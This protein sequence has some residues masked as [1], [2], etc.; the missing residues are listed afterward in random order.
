MTV[1]RL[2]TVATFV[3]DK[4]AG[5]AGVVDDM[6]AGAEIRLPPLMMPSSVRSPPGEPPIVKT[7]GLVIE[8]VLRLAMSSRHADVC[9]SDRRL[10]ADVGNHHIVDCRIGNARCVLRS[11][12]WL[13]P[14]GG[15]VPVSAAGTIP[16]HQR[17]DVR[18]RWDRRTR[19]RI[20]SQDVGE[21]A[22]RDSALGLH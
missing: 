3:D 11:A 9:R 8:S 7:R 14:V 6:C 17:V 20:G 13:R 19:L 4:T 1:D 21:I 5:A 18:L 12:G 2:I 10:R 22:A 15:R 16:D